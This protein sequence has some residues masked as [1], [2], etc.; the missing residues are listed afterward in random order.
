[1]N[2]GRRL[3]L[4]WIAP[5]ALCAILCSSPTFAA[6]LCAYTSVCPKQ[7]ERLQ[8]KTPVNAHDSVGSSTSCCPVHKRKPM[9]PSGPFDCCARG[10]ADFL[11]RAAFSPTANQ[12]PI[13]LRSN[14]LDLLP[15]ASNVPLAGFETLSLY[16]KPVQ[17]KKTD[18]RI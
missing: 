15:A 10:P 14:A 8:V 18:L 17:Q 6:L 3:Q 7:A 11:L 2:S 4:R 1:M 12:R 13:A 16:V 5:V 9:V